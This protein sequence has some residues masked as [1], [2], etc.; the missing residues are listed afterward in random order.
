MVGNLGEEL[1]GA[2][3]LYKYTWLP[4]C[5]KSGTN[6]E[7]GTASAAWA[8]FFTA[9]AMV[10]VAALVADATIKERTDTKLTLAAELTLATA[11]VAAR[12]GSLKGRGG[13]VA[14]TNT[15]VAFPRQRMAGDRALFCLDCWFPPFS[16]LP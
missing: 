10:K 3:D 16:L 9:V 14:P 1:D 12:V 7:R 6:I 5:T 2:V 15:L 4:M 13:G 8:S 11:A